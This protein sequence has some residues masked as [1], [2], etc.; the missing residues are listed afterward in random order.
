MKK[1]CRSCW[2]CTDKH[3]EMSW[4]VALQANV[5]TK[6]LRTN[7]RHYGAHKRE[8]ICDPPFPYSSGIF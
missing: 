2:A 6:K 1:T 4:C 5:N 7:C 8:R 3:L